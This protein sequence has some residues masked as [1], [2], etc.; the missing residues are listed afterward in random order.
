MVK[1][2]L[3]IRDARII[4]PFRGVDD[5]GDVWI[6]HGVVV[7]PG[8]I[9]PETT[10]DAHGL[11]L[12]PRITDMH[13]HFR[14]PGQTWKEDVG[15][16]SRAAAAGGFTQVMTMANTDPVVDS[17]SLVA[18]LAERGRQEGLVRILPGAAITRGSEGRQLTDFYRLK[19]AG[20]V[21]F[22]DDGRPVESAAV[23]QAA[24]AYSRTVGA[25]VINHA[26]EMSLSRQAVVHQGAPAL[27][28]GLAGAGELAESLMVWRDVQLAGATGG[29]LHVAHVSVPH[30]LEAIRYARDHGW[31][32]TAEA[33]PHHLFFT[34]E[35]LREWG[36]DPVT[37][38][39]PP[40][41]PGAFREAL[42]RAVASGLVGVAAT[43]HAPHAADEK[44]LPY[45]EA[46]F[47]I[48]GLETAIGALLTVLL[49][50]GL[51]TPLALFALL[52]VGPHQVLRLAYP[53]LVP[54]APADLTLIDPD[55][56]WLV[57]PKAFYSR[58]HNTPFSGQRLRGRAVATML[59]G[60]WTMLDGEVSS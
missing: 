38:V 19:A 15:S 47:G 50:S 33:T 45:A 39:N 13:V 20:A 32:V 6:D 29:I 35:I 34:D 30:S 8:T 40:L 23:M 36:Y 41:R 10:F 9:H 31:Q 49:H 59:D 46:P 60:V 53:G 21:G 56:E 16:G 3:R 24:L 58:G 52:T 42:Q 28:M 4:D 11:W 43:D 7:E 1:T 17:P 22:S 14:D 55:R 37:K 48:A 2:A 54:G 18:W 26:Q 12:V 57:D 5:V 27:E 51:M 25:P 44:S